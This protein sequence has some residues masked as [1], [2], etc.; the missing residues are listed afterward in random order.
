M[1]GVTEPFSVL[2]GQWVVYPAHRFIH[3]TESGCSI[4]SC[5][6]TP[7]WQCSTG[8]RFVLGCTCR[9]SSCRSGQGRVRSACQHRSQILW[10]LHW[11][12]GLVRLQVGGQA[13]LCRLRRKIKEIGGMYCVHVSAHA[14]YLRS[15]LGNLVCRLNCL[16]S[17]RDSSSQ[18]QMRTVCLLSLFLKG[19]HQL[20]QTGEEQKAVTAGT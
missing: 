14:L 20:L 2:V 12:P 16:L 19:T 17:S 1:A 13:E 7:C 6:Q 5:H 11:A 15:N 18:Q 9:I 4:C 10:C 3:F 8:R